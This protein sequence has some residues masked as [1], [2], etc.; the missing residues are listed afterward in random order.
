MEEK[1]YTNIEEAQEALQRGET[2]RIAVTSLHIDPKL[3]QLALDIQG[4][5]RVEAWKQQQQTRDQNDERKERS[6]N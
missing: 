3:V 2:V 1:I 4:K 6:A 5:E